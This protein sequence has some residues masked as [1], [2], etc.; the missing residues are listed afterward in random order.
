MSRRALALF[1]VVSALSGSAYLFMAVAVETLPAAVVAEGRVAIGAALLLPLALRRGE[2]GALRGR[3]R[4][5]V[6]LAVLEFAAP[7]LLIIAGSARIPSSLVGVLMAAGP[8]VTVAFARRYDATQVVGGMRLAG[9]LAGAA[10]VV[11][12]LGVEV[13]GGGAGLAGAGLVLAGCGSFAA[14][15][16]YLHRHFVG[17]PTIGLVGT[18]LAISAVVLLVPAALTAPGSDPTA[19]SLL[20]V[21]A[22]GVF[23]GAVN[24]SLFGMLVATA[25]ASRAAVTAYVAPV[26]SVLL[27]VLVLGEPLGAGLAVGLPLILAGSWLA[28]DSPGRRTGG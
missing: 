21:V 9:M 17:V 3:R 19:Q 20:A 2:L 14:G 26:V 10:G 24:F 23:Y 6:V 11:L 27:G 12:L 28:T 1:V 16:L 13:G 18:C 15:G 5:L 25:G 22:L 7:F 4:S 8:I